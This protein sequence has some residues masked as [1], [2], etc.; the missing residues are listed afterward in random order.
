MEFSHI[1][2]E[3]NFTVEEMIEVIYKD[4]RYPATDQVMCLSLKDAH[5]MARDLNNFMADIPY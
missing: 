1:K 4:A 2:K 3:K 5:D